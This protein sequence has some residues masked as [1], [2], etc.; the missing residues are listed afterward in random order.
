MGEISGRLLRQ[1]EVAQMIGMS[2]AWLEQSRFRGTGIPY[3]KCGRSVRYRH[4]DVIEWLEMH[5]VK[6]AQKG[7]GRV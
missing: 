2:E 3:I 7:G 6:C 5:S 1:R 4:S